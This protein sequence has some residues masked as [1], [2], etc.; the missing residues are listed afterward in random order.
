MTIQL[1][2][3]TFLLAALSTGAA[4]TLVS[5]A[6]LMPAIAAE[7]DQP[8]AIAACSPGPDFSPDVSSDFSADFSGGL[9]QTQLKNLSHRLHGGEGQTKSGVPI[10]VEYP[11]LDFTAAESNAAVQ[12]FGCDCPAC[13][14][15]LRQLQAQRELNMNG[16]GHCLTNLEER[17]T[18]EEVQSV[19]DGLSN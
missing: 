11:E 6:W 12:L 13:L 1:R 18:P 5:L 15:T 9:E 8:A 14:T 16:Q 4:A 17:A 19:L 10:V 3:F 7:P 2:R